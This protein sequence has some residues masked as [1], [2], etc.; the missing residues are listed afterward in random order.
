MNMP[1]VDMIATGRR[2][3]DLRKIAGLSVKD[4]Q[5]VFGFTTPQAIY[6]WQHGS[7]L[8]TIDN[9]IVLSAVLGVPMDEII[10]IGDSN[11]K[12]SARPEAGL[13]CDIYSSLYILI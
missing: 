7:D 11:A 12:L 2:I 10:V 8:P 13:L 1:V 5:D 9:L 3:Q 4:L 6:K